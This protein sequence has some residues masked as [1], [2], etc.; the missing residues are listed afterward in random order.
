MN[1][2]RLVTPESIAKRIAEGRGQG[3]RSS[4]QPW[5][6]VQDFPS[7]GRVHR[8]KG[9]ANGRVHHL[10]SDLE[11]Y[12]FLIY[13]WSRHSIIDIREQYPLLPVEETLAIASDLGI[14]HP[15]DQRTKYPVVLTTDFFLTINNNLNTRYV[16]RTA[17]YLI[18]L[19]KPRTLEKF[20]IERRYW[21]R[22]KIPWGIVTEQDLPMALVHNVRWLHPYFLLIDLYPMTEQ[23]INE[24]TLVLTEKI[25]EGRTPLSE[26]ARLCD[27]VLGIRRGS[28]LSVGRHLLANRFW[29]VDMHKALHLRE[30]LILLNEPKD[31]MYREKITA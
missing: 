19:L 17:K 16:A 28:S 6:F 25:I 30:P 22:R 2:G 9:W 15:T 31:V 4:Y 14:R 26:V 10:F 23:I 12:I 18:D 29:H 7:R 3:E 5:H 27:D 20:E 24:I 21:E 1:S 11:L 8:I 13:E